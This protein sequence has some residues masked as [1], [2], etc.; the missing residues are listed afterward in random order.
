MTSSLV[1]FDASGSGVCENCGKPV[2]LT[3][4]GRH[5]IFVHTG[6]AW[7]DPRSTQCEVTA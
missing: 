2:H 1:A 3:Q 5:S 6:I 4:I 7:S